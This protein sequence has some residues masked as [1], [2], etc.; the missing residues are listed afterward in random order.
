MTDRTEVKSFTSLKHQA[1]LCGEMLAGICAP[2][3]SSTLSLLSNSPSS[4]ILWK[5]I[6]DWGMARIIKEHIHCLVVIQEGQE[7]HLSSDSGPS[8]YKENQRIDWSFQLLSDHQPEY[9]PV[10]TQ[11][12]CT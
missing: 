1:G 2:L 3:Y 8:N 9:F 11:Q 6:E 10:I 5:Q 7:T 12:A 4:V